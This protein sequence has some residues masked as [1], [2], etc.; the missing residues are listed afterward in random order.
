MP[1]L[2]V[3]E[4][5]IYY[6]VQGEGPP[7]IL[8]HPPLLSSRNFY[9]QVEELSKSNQVITFDIRGHGR[10][11][12]SST[13]LSY[14]LI[15]ED[16][17]TLLDHLQ[18][19]KAFLCGYSMGASVALQ[20][21]LQAPERVSGAILLGGISQIVKG[22]LQKMIAL[23]TVLSKRYAISLLAQTISWSNAN[24]WRMYQYLLQDAKKANSQNVSEY[25]YQGLIFD[26]TEM[27]P[28][29]T[30]PV[31]LLYGENDRTIEPFASILYHNLPNRELK[32]IPKV[33]HQLPTKA[34]K[35]VNQAIHYF[36]RKN[37]E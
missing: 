1:F 30:A 18:I 6:H 35:E 16:M 29:I 26:C 12:P 7:I 8:I 32:L 25:Y 37:Q 33:K 14:A 3:P 31:L 17:L 5:S 15:V 11:T 28:S 23:A 19:Q 13:P 10:S 20:F 9:H 27:L 2:D 4:G 21:M 36:I 34:Y 24:N 22:R